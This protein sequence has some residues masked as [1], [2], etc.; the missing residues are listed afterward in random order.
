MR[1]PVFSVLVLV[2]FIASGCG[3]AVPDGAVETGADGATPVAQIAGDPIAP[4]APVAPKVYDGPP[5]TFTPR[6]HPPRTRYG[7][8][9]TPDLRGLPRLIYKPNKC[10]QRDRERAPRISGSSAMVRGRGG[11]SGGG[12]GGKPSSASAKPKPPPGPTSQPPAAASGSVNDLLGGTTGAAPNVATAA[13]TATESAPTT[14]TA[15]MAE[16]A[17]DAVMASAPDGDMAEREEAMPTG[18]EDAKKIATDETA[19]A[20]LDTV[21]D[22]SEETMQYDDWGAAIY[23]SNDDTMSLSSAQRVLYAIDNFLPLSPNH[24]R[25]H[26]LLNYF[27]FDTLP[28]DSGSDFSV[29]A[30]M[31]PDPREEGIQSLALSVD[32]RP[33]DKSSR[34]NTA[35]TL[36]IDRSGSMRDEGRMNYLKQG[37]GRMLSELKDGDMVHMVLFDHD[38]C[39]PAENFVVGRDNPRKLEKVIDKLKPR[40]STDLH[41]GLTRGYQIADRRFQNTFSNRVIMITDALTNT[42]VTNQEMIAM[43]GKYYDARRIRLSGIGVGRNFNDALLDRLTER[44]KGAYIFLGSEAEVDAVFG[45]RFVSLIETTALDVHFRLHL[46]PSLRMNVFYGEESSTVKADVQEIHYFA[47]TSQLFLSDLM[48]R[49]GKVRPEDGVMLTI[50]YKDPETAEPLVE[51]YAFVLGDIMD[52]DANVKK[53]RLIMAWVDMLAESAYRPRPSYFRPSAG[54]WQD[55]EGWQR[56]DDGTK[57][58]AGLATGLEQDPEVRRVL[59]LFEKYCTRYE[60]PRHPVKREIPAKKDAWPGA[61]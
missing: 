34:R 29:Y 16:P 25:P 24:I 36:V 37:L 57:V 8:A 39:V 17:P 42:G 21:E 9:Q 49:G 4:V 12:Y 50:E 28:V 15:P 40:G 48:T 53:S 27:S 30:E 44:G 38:V 7:N 55:P 2:V 45:N 10:F 1:N 60:K 26:E 51:E 11:A 61:K 59:S 52:R 56:C 23:L 46:P 47:G 13:A 43:I 58:L 5:H 3:P 41:R 32:G 20:S 35:I 22:T 54:A 6:S 19:G 18:G 33:V 14:P 31:A